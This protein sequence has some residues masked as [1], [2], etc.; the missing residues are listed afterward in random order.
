ML[1]RSVSE[2]CELMKGKLAV[3]IRRTS[4]ATGI[5]YGSVQK[6]VKSILKLHPYKLKILHQLKP[7]DYAK[8]VA[9]AKWFLSIKDL[10]KNFKATDEAYFHLN[11]AVNN[12]NC[13]I[14]D[15]KDPELI[16]EEP[17]KSPKVMVW[18]AVTC[19]KVIGPFFFNTTVKHDN[20]LDML[21]DYFWPR[22][23]RTKD[24]SSYYF[25]QD[26]APAHRHEEVQEIGR[27]HV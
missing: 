4:E 5:S 25:Q 27:A 8:R 17:I 24:N 2:V 22:W 7:P 3:S 11:G 12:Y 16:H 20:Y 9:F 18:C 10:A 21:K 13:R 15:D 23:Y 26:G 14:W 6:I 19:N 1:F